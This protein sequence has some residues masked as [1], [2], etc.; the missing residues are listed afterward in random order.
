MKLKYPYLNSIDVWEDQLFV[1]VSEF[2]GDGLTALQLLRDLLPVI[3]GDYFVVTTV[4]RDQLKIS[5]FFK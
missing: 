1:E 2:A 5:F 3:L 4:V